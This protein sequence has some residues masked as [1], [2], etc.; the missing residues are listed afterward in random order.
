VDFP[1][2]P[3]KEA[4]IKPSIFNAIN[5]T[6][7]FNRESKYYDAKRQRVKNIISSTATDCFLTFV[8]KPSTMPVGADPVATLTSHWKNGDTRTLD[9]ANVVKLTD[10]YVYY[11]EMTNYYLKDGEV[12]F[13]VTVAGYDDIIYSEICDFVLS[14]DFVSRNI[15]Q[16]IAY[17]NNNNRGYV[18]VTYPAC[19]FI[20]VS[21]F[22][23]NEVQENKTEYKYSFGR[24]EILD[25]EIYIKK[26]MTFINP[27]MYQRNL[28]K[29]LC[30][31]QNKT[32][33]G[34]EYCLVGDFVDVQRNDGSEIWDL[35]ANF[36]LKADP[37]FYATGAT[38]APSSIDPTN[39]FIH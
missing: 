2:E 25:N 15:V 27:S 29:I 9:H 8:F 19:M 13:D 17:N 35:E 11:F 36:V 7:D 26:K 33:N 23:C 4:M 28:L 18:D 1:D 37:T 6:D 22:N 24:S 30:G 20:E 32:I 34:I 12:Y 31:L 5:F 3:K 16:I 10:M 21:D 39:L 38:Q 14:S